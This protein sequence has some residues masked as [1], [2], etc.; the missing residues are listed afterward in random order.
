M[1]T[2]EEKIEKLNT[3]SVIVT[4]LTVTFDMGLEFTI[5]TAKGVTTQMGN[6]GQWPCFVFNM[7][8][9]TRSLLDK[10]QTSVEV[11]D[12]LVLS[13][14]LGATLTTYHDFYNGDSHFDENKASQILSILRE[15]IQNVKNIGDRLY[16]YASPEEWNM[17]FGLFATM[18]EL[19]DFFIKIWGSDEELYENMT[20]EEIDDYYIKAEEEDFFSLPYQVIDFEDEVK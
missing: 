15:K 10:L 2:R 5:M 12:E 14:S 19:T 7:I 9:Q 17:K 3:V 4:D 1:M 8:N 11:S 13:T 20:D 6:I 16:V 18:D